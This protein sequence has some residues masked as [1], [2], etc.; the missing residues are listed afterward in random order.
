MGR[1]DE[2]ISSCSDCKGNLDDDDFMI[3]KDCKKEKPIFV[4]GNNEKG[5][6]S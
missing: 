2:I 5:G 4:Y 6:E 3:C 1:L